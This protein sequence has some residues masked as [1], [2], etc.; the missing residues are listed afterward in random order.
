MNKTVNEMEDYLE[1]L[2]EKEDPILIG[3]SVSEVLRLKFLPS[4][5]TKDD[6]ALFEFIMSYRWGQDYGCDAN[7]ISA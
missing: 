5:P 7:F 6:I 1:E 4:K 3:K 2:K